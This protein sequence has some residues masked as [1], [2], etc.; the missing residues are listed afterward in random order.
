MAFALGLPAYSSFL[1]FTRAF[2][3]RGD[4]KTPALVNA[5]TMVVAS[6]AGAALFFAGS[7]GS[8]SVPGL[9]LGHSIAFTLGTLVMA[10]IFGRRSGA[11][12]GTKLNAAILRA[13]LAAA[14]ALIA[15]FVVATFLGDADRSDALV[16][17]L[18]VGLLGGGVYLGVEAGM[19]SPELA[20]L[21]TLVRSRG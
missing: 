2:Y 19:G 5:G 1:V 18:V 9:A 13:A 8:W 4:T 3:A 16:Q 6:I 15:M 12:G 11:V 7:D 17:V 21:R 10:R 14:A 20:R